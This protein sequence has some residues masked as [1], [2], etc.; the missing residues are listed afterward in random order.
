MKKNNSK[1][2]YFKVSVETHLYLISLKYAGGYK[3]IDELLKDQFG[4]KNKK[5][6]K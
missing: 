2:R 4:I 3:S 6:K 5:V 1:N